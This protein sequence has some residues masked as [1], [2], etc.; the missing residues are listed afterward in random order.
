MAAASGRRPKSGWVPKW[1]TGAP[2]WD[3]VTTGDN[4]FHR[5]HNGGDRWCVDLGDRFAVGSAAFIKHEDS[6]GWSFCI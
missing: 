2:K 1:C 4:R 3:V 5:F 6:A